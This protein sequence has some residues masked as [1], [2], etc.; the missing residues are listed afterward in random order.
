MLICGYE[1]GR[2]II[3]DISYE[4]CK[5]LYDEKVMEDSCIDADLHIDDLV[6]VGAGKSITIIRNPFSKTPSAT[7]LSIPESGINSIT[8][9]SDG[10]LFVT[11]GWDCK[12]RF[13]SLKTGKLLAVIN[14]HYEAI[15]DVKI[16]KLGGRK[17][18]TAA[19]S[20]DGTVSLWSLYS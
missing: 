6:A 1:N 17:F 10:K 13:F 5:V 19:A 4:H 8:I 3:S 18:V 15:T 7:K 12:L 11:G 20:S 14:H 2:V 16:F 9:R